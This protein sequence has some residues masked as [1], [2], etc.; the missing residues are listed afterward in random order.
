MESRKLLRKPAITNAVSREVSPAGALTLA[1]GNQAHSF[2]WLMAHGL[3][4]VLSCFRV[5]VALLSC[6]CGPRLFVGYCNTSNMYEYFTMNARFTGP[7]P[8]MASVS[9][10]TT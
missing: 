8:L 4:V 10:Y 2:G 5:F 3:G 6:L 1:L 7:R 9:L